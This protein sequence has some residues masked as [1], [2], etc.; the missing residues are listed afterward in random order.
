MSLSTCAKVGSLAGGKK[1]VLPPVVVKSEPPNFTINFKGQKIEITFDEFIVLDNISQQLVV[2]P[3]VENRVDVRLKNKTILINLNNELQDSTTYTLNFGEA[4]KDN[5]EGNPFYNYEYVFSTG[6]FLDS[7]S[8]YGR[9]VN[10]FDLKPQ[11]DPVSILLYQDLDDSAFMKH[12]PLYVGKTDKEGY[13]AMNNLKSD[14]FHIFALKDLNSNYRFDLPDEEIAFLDTSIFLTP[15]LFTR[16]VVDTLAIDSLAA[17]GAD[18]LRLSKQDSIARLSS[19]KVTDKLLVDLYLFRENNERQY[20]TDYSRKEK[21]RLEF[22]LNR[23]VTDSFLIT[24]IEPEQNKWYLLEKNIENDSFRL[25]IKEPLVIDMDTVRLALTYTGTDST[26]N[27]VSKKD[28]LIFG[29]REPVKS[30]KKT[31]EEA[32]TTLKISTINNQATL[33]LNQHVVFNAE[34]PLVAIDTSFF[35]LRSKEDSLMVPESFVVMRDT[36]NIRKAQLFCEWKEKTLYGLTLLPKAFTDIYGHVN[37]TINIKFTTRNEGYYGVLHLNIKGVQCPVIVQLMDAKESIVRETI[38][39]NDGKVTFDFLKPAQYK[40]KFIYDCNGNGKWD[41]GKYIIG[42]QPEKV[43][44]YTGD[45]NV[46][47]NWEIEISET[48]G[49]PAGN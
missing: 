1:D 41:T 20:I 45:I 42:I 24:S 37:D 36:T 23:P 2:S 8:V 47:S 9:L 16:H 7:L 14:T 39:Q 28:T 32:D 12:I 48:L 21:N 46:R 13:F 40:V 10:A 33:E 25:W 15:E 4:I 43:A 26:G 49:G 31:Q 30:K 34:M 6:D 29:Y 27:K 19:K 5:N 3:P 44:Y 38:V 18:S 22:S 35:L 17:M 11:E